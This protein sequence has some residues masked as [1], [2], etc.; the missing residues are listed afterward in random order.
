[1][2]TSGYIVKK[3]FTKHPAPHSMLL[4]WTA[5]YLCC[6]AVFHFLFLWIACFFEKNDDFLASFISRL[7]ETRYFI[8]NLNP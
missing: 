3:Y 1:S 7:T 8:L 5:I 4:Y 6:Q 2:P